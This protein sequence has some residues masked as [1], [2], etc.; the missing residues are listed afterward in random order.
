MMQYEH[1]FIYRIMPDLTNSIKALTK[2]IKR[3]NDNKDAER[4]DFVSALK[5][6][7]YSIEDFISN[8]GVVL[9]DQNEVD[10][11]ESLAWLSEVYENIDIRV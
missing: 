4:P 1:D 3:Y 6:K 9:C 5:M 10:V 8:V 7:G 11:A 2:E